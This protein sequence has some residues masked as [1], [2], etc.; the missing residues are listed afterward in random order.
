MD[1][2]TCL[3]QLP[4]IKVEDER[5]ESELHRSPLKSWA[6][7]ARGDRQESTSCPCLRRTRARLESLFGK[8]NAAP[9]P[10]RLFRDRTD[11]GRNLAARLS[12]YGRSDVLVLALPRGGVPVAHEV[13]VRLGVPLDVF[14]VRKLGVP[15]RPELAMGAIATGGVEVLSKDLIHD[16]GI[17]ASVVEQVASRERVELDRRDRLFRG[18]RRPPN[19]ADRTV[20]LVDD[21][22]ATGASMEAAITALKPMQPAAIVVAVPVA[23]REACERLTRIADRVVCLATP[24]PF[25]AVGLWYD[26]FSQTTDA[27]V[28]RLLANP[29]PA[30]A[31]NGVGRSA[32]S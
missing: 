13:A 31:G 20:L 25:D 21:G 10:M 9:T 22:L 8:T 15:E 17:P 32:R 19:V 1:L 5:P 18:D 14:L 30:S 2:V 27:E 24:S 28:Q 4:G 23:A 3:R 6:I 7:L 29:S 11:A 26:D 12:E 16:L